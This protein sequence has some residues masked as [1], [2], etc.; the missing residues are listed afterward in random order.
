MEWRSVWELG[1]ELV[2]GLAD[3]QMFT[4]LRNM[5]II[6]AMILGTCALKMLQLAGAI[7]HP[8][9]PVS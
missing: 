3:Q 9:R 2:Y 4:A 8:E 6:I 7:P 5:S 1:W